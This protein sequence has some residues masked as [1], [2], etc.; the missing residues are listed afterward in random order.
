MDGC[1]RDNQRWFR[2]INN[3]CV[4]KVPTF[5]LAE[6]MLLLPPGLTPPHLYVAGEEVWAMGMIS[7]VTR[8]HRGH[9]LHEH[10]V[11]SSCS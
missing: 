6:T 9:V 1:D 11:M 8:G 7:V 2:F 5:A 3:K 4:C 10:G